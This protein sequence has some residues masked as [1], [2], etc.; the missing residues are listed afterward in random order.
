MNKWNIPIKKYI[1]SIQLTQSI[2]WNTLAR[3]IIAEK[4]IIY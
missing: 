3:Y 4:A 2:H 1:E